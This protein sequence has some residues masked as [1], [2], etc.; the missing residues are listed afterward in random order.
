MQNHR[1]EC[2]LSD[3][4]TSINFICRRLDSMPF[5]IRYV[6]QIAINDI[7]ST[8]ASLYLDVCSFETVHG[9]IIIVY[10][11]INISASLHCY[12]SKRR[13]TSNGC[14]FFVVR[15]SLVCYFMNFHHLID[16]MHFECSTILLSYSLPSS[17][18]LQ[19]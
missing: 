11:I 17:R 2:F 7:A 9:K 19:P 5:G 15:P 18:Q 4:S 3:F 16:L 13:L 8:S 14:I 6:Q 12:S 1:A 10:C